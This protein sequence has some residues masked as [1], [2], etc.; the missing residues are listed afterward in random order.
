MVSGPCDRLLCGQC[1]LLALA[2]VQAPELVDVAEG[3]GGAVGI[4]VMSGLMEAGCAHDLEPV[5]LVSWPA[6][7]RLRPLLKPRA[8]NVP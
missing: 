3:P 7:R 2:L 8:F 1:A 6:P 4:A 5:P